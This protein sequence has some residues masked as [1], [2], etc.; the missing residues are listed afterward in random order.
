MHKLIE[1]SR[2]LIEALP[3]IKRFFKKTFV[4]KYGGSAMKIK[5]YKEIFFQDIALLSYVSINIIIVHDG[6][7]DISKMLQKIG[8]KPIFVNNTHS[9]YQIVSSQTALIIA[10]QGNTLVREV[11][12]VGRD[13]STQGKIDVP[14]LTLQQISGKAQR[15]ISQAVGSG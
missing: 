14:I 8:K 9:Y 7:D 11:I 2:V 5:K 10:G 6:G 12:A 3:Y 13:F 15:N 4:I 1:K